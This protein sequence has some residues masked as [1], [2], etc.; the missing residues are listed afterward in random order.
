MVDYDEYLKA[1]KKNKLREVKELL[2]ETA[3][4]GVADIEP[5]YAIAVGGIIDHVV[6]SKKQADSIT[7]Q[8]AGDDT[9]PAAVTT[10]RLW[11]IVEFEQEDEFTDDS[12]CCGE[13]FMVKGEF[14][15]EE[16]GN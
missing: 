15:Q 14:Q 7:A 16:L 2:E 8:L 13:P 6:S 10:I 5:L 1:S 11:Q 4:D 12:K 3:V 9:L